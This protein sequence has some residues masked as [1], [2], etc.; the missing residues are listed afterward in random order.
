MFFKKLKQGLEKTRSSFRSLL[1]ITALNEETLEQIEE[2]LLLAD[3]NFELTQSILKKLKNKA[4]PKEINQEQ[5]LKYLKQSTL[6]T[7]SFPVASQVELKKPHVCLVLGVNGVGKT[8]TIA[9]LAHHYQN[10]GKKVLLAAADTFRAGAVKQLVLWGKKLNTQ[11]VTPKDSNSP[12]AVAYNSYE[13][14]IEQNYD[15]LLIDTAGRLHN[16]KHLMGEMEK[17]IRT[18]KKH[19]ENLPSENLLVIDSNTGQNAIEQAKA[20]H[21]LE[22]LTGLIVT[23]LDGTTKG[24]S[25]LSIIDQLNIP[26][27][28]IGTG[29]TLNDLIP[30][31]AKEYVEGLFQ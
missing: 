27:R 26:I 28:F 18:L 20:F 31:K 21:S 4:T 9:K 17:I 24:G 19:D 15:V 29:E 3:I 7:I 6:E 13:V 16:K 8:T 5:L 10:Q 1:K 30:F 23:K 12:S 25:V 14:C 2:S 11:V 22:E